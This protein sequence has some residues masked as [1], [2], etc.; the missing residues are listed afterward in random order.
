MFGK[1]LVHH[2]F[3]KEDGSLLVHSIWPTIQGEGPDAGRPAVFVRLSRCNLRC[4][5]CDTDFSDGKW[6]SAGAVRDRVLELRG[7]SKLVVITGGE[8]LLQNIIPLTRMLGERGLSV[9]IET[10]GSVY[11]EGLETL[12][13]ADLTVHYIVCSPKTP[14]LNWQI[15][16]L[17]RAYK[18]IV[19]ENQVDSKDGLPIYSTQIPDKGQR[20]ARP[21]SGARVYVQACDVGDPFQNERNVK[22]A[23]KL[24]MQHGYLLSVQIHKLVGVE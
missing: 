2:Q 13:D 9:G 17:I 23:A 15:I 21:P 18:Y 12:F 24:A 3:A 10:A 7:K 8:P 20:I 14:V 4:H 11:L 5:F 6:M 22:L 16:K 19:A 1:N